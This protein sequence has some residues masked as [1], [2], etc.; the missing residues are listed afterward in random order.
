M[1]QR[2]YVLAAPRTVPPGRAALVRIVTTR[3]VM[4]R[5]FDPRTGSRAERS[6]ERSP[7]PVGEAVA[8]PAVALVVDDE[9]G[10]RTVVA[11]QLVRLGWVVRALPSA[12]AALEWLAE[13]ADVEPPHLVVSDI[14]MP[15]LTGVD[16]ATILRRDH[17]TLGVLLMSG[18]AAPGLTPLRL[19]TPPARGGSAAE[20]FVWLIGKP[21]DLS[22]LGD[23]VARTVLRHWGAPRTSGSS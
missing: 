20:Q 12:E 13:R 5:D 8:T 10:V 11:R 1:Q 4:R 9:P 19:P 15:G 7:E 22:A 3:P 21:Y 23:A 17:P 14:D 6:G 16:L 2:G 18:R